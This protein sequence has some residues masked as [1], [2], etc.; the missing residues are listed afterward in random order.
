MAATI[1]LGDPRSFRVRI[2]FFVETLEQNLSKLRIAFL[3]IVV[4][5]SGLHTNMT[6][7]LSSMTH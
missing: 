1:E 4:F 5:F 7:Q 2:R 3:A 6:Q